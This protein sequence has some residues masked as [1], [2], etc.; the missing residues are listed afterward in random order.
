[1]FESAING[2]FFFFPVNKLYFFLI[3]AIHI[4]ESSFVTAQ[5]PPPKAGII[6]QKQPQP[7]SMWL[8]IAVC[9]S[10]PFETP[11]SRNSSKE[12]WLGPIVMPEG[13]NVNKFVAV[14]DCEAVQSI[15]G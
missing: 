4:I 11:S 3:D 7:M 6:F 2:I 10:L 14:F 13:C 5:S 9:I 12:M 1:M 15:V 8:A